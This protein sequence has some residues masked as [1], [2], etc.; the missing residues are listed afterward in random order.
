MNHSSM[1]IYVVSL[2]SALALN[3]PQLTSIGLYSTFIVCTLPFFQSIF[4]LLGNIPKPDDT[5]NLC[6]LFQLLY[7][8][9][10]AFK[11]QHILT[12]LS[13]IS[14][15]SIRNSQKYIWEE[16]KAI[17]RWKSIAHPNVFFLLYSV[18]KLIF[19]C[20]VVKHILCSTTGTSGWSASDYRL[21]QLLLET[22]INWNTQSYYQNFSLKFIIV[23]E[24]NPFNSELLSNP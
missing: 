21:T 15:R 8:L 18:K 10:Q 6:N 22:E 5:L 13:A 19:I 23:I 17:W 20:W 11:T 2:L 1:F 24:P 3:R 9:T 4:T 14:L 7:S 16:N 12:K